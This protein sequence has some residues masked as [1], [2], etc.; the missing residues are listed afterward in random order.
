[1]D[2]APNY[3]RL[4]ID[5]LFQKNAYLFSPRLQRR[6]H[7][8][9]FGVAMPVK[10][11][12]GQVLRKID[13]TGKRKI[14][15]TSLREEPVI[16]VNGKPYVLRSFQDP[17]KNLEATGIV[18]ERVESMESRMKTDAIEELRRYGGRLLLH[19]EESD[20][21]S[22]TVTVSGI[23]NFGFVNLIHIA[24]VLAYLGKFT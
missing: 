12:I 11:A 6:A 13:P 3:R 16:Y 17:L 19:G 10:D 22:F 8:N 18:R 5:N 14:L 4:D 1:V 21:T 20:G 15:W 7:G 23:I 2:G 9:I 24:L